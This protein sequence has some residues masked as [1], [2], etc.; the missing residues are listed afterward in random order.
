DQA[1]LIAGY[2]L[3][4]AAVVGPLL[5]LVG[6]E[7]RRSILLAS[8]GA[9]ALT[10]FG[11]LYRSS[12]SVAFSALLAVAAGRAG[13]LLAGTSA[14]G[15]MRTVDM[16]A[17]GGGWRYMP[18]T[19]ASLLVAALV[20]SLGGVGA[21]MARVAWPAGIALGAA[22]VVVAFSAFRPYFA[23]AHGPLRR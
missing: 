1:L 21:V 15:A 19:S 18:A 22:L 4:V 20:L 10:L 17:T 12:A 13:M 6:V 14:A 16:R 8:S 2:T 5:G 3:G 7:L 9:V 11:L 23:V